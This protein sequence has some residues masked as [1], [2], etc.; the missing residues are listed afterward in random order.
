LKTELETEN[1]LKIK[2]LFY[3]EQIS[4]YNKKLKDENS[5]L[6]KRLNEK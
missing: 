1:N 6:K 2:G 5:N 3:K 4:K